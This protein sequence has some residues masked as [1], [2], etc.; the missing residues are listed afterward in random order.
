MLEQNLGAMVSP[1]SETESNPTSG[2]RR[3]L[4][5]PDIDLDNTSHSLMSGVGSDK[6]GPTVS[7][8]GGGNG[9]QMVLEQNLGATRA[10]E[11]EEEDLEEEE[12]EEDHE[13]DHEK[14]LDSMLGEDS[15]LSS[16]IPVQGTLRYYEM[17]QKS[18]I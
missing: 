18:I 3:M 5:P 6:E 15:N 1:R 11:E 14:P 9:A 16:D 7:N 2:G 8:S 13:D 10:R 4:N 17:G 12:E